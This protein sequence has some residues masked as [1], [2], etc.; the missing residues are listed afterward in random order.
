MGNRPRNIV[1]IG[2]KACG[3]SAVGKALADRLNLEF[4][5][6]DRLIESAHEGK[7]GQAISF[8]EIYQRLGGDYFRELEQ[9]VLDHAVKSEEA[10]ISLGGGS[11]MGALDPESLLQESFCVYL[12]VEPDILFGRI[13]SGGVPAFFDPENPRVSFKEL[14]AG[15]LPVYER[16]ADITVDNTDRP[17]EEVAEE[18]ATALEKRYQHINGGMS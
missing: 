15:R 8:R 12:S 7:T 5:D 18:I 16:L 9:S 11:I 10:V 13:M 17:V 1:I 14:C 2:F 6:L 3:K 4:I